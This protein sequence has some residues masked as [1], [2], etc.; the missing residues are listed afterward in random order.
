MKLMQ[1]RTDTINYNHCNSILDDFLTCCVS[2]IMQTKEKQIID[3]LKK[4]GFEFESKDQLKYF[5]KT[6]CEI[7]IRGNLNKLY[8]DNKMI[9]KWRNI[10]EIKYEGN[11]VTIFSELPNII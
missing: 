3:I 5:V 6:R 7:Q 8:V 1:T 10:I 9:C 2:K 4:N 11:K